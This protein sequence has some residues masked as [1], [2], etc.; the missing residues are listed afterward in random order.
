[1][2]D[3]RAHTCVQDLC[4]LRVPTLSV[5]SHQLQSGTHKA[6]WVLQRISFCMPRLR[7]PPDLHILTNLTDASVLLS[8]RVKTLSIWIEP[9]EAR[10]IFTTRDGPYGLQNSL[11]TLTS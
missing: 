11:C 10:Y 9:F 2:N 4:P 1:M 6:S 7:T 3:T 8:V 5:S